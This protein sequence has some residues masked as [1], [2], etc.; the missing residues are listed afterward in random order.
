MALASTAASAEVVVA[1]P[2]GK[3]TNDGPTNAS[4]PGVGFDRWFANNVRAG[5]SVGITTTYANNGNGS[6]EFSGPANAKAD[7][8]YYFS[9]ANQF[10]LS[11]LTGLSF[12]YLR[13]D[14]STAAAWLAPAIRLA[15]TNG[16][17]SGYLVYENVYN[18]VQVTP[19]NS[20]VSQDVTSAKVWGTGNLPGAFSE[21]GRTFA[22]WNTLLPNLRVTALSVGI[23]S[24][25]NGSFSGAV[26][27]VSYSVNGNNTT[28]NFEA[29]TPAVPEPSTWMML[30]LGFGVIGYAMRRKT[31]LRYV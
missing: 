5:G 29:A 28:F 22:D 3:F 9:A 13:S 20:F 25:W 15:V 24:G 1:S 7:F 21:Y 4:G 31:V 8:E 23:G 14:S 26:D 2:T 11:D 27:R 6:L 16:T 12:D 17:N 19:V 18:G 30:V 10:N